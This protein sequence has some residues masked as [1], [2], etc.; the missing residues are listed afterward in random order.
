MKIKS[1]LEDLFPKKT[2][3][4]TLS[5]KFTSISISIAIFV[6][7]I[8][9]IYQY[10][11]LIVLMKQYTLDKEKKYESFTTLIQEDIKYK[12][13]KNDFGAIAS[14]TNELV[15]SNTIL[16][17]SII[18]YKDKKIVWSS[19]KGYDYNYSRTDSVVNNLKNLY[20]KNHKNLSG[21]S[22]FEM[23]PMYDKYILQ[24]GY[25]DSNSMSEIIKVILDGN[26]KLIIVFIFFSFISTYL[27]FRIIS[28]PIQNLV[29]GTEEFAKG[30][31]SFRV[32][33]TTHDEIGKLSDSFNKMADRLKILYTSLE[34]RVK[35]RTLEIEVANIELKD[36][37]KQLQETQAMLIHGEKMQSL[38]QM[39]AG[40]AHELNNPINFIY[41]NLEH[42]KNYTQDLIDIIE[43]YQKVSPEL[44]EESLE[45][46][47]QV[48]ED[49]D[50]EFLVDDIP[51]LI[52]SCKD[53]AERCKQIV[54]DLKNFSRLDEAVLKEVDIHEGIDSTLNILINKFK[55]K[56]TI[57]KEYGELP[58]L[59][60][61]AGQLNQV[62]MNILDNSAQAIQD[63]GVIYIRTSFVNNN[64]VIEFEDNGKGISKENLSKIF[65]PFFT[66]KPVGEGTGIGLSIS[67]KIIKTHNGTIIVDSEE[68]KGTRFKISIPLKWYETSEK[69]KKNSSDQVK[70]I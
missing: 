57:N 6:S 34:Q 52:K 46:V 36:A 49:C 22:I 19:I 70:L 40:V 15:H 44:S 61:Y 47:T 68:N 30:N 60:C 37:Y 1:I 16:Y 12:V 27:L 43:T 11:S 31:L 33:T 50:Y 54:L 23:D 7:F 62:F 35:D 20:L 13:I 5:D 53:G 67:F 8:L 42:L 4:R 39:V 65:D 48:R 32:K 2:K 18:D 26:V 17:L 21:N 38:G 56:I 10:Y 3:Y 59:S 29:L 63:S 64:I 41:G 58:K 51:S 24:I 55:N 66:T 25:Y 45:E 14:F 9:S 28:K 69:N